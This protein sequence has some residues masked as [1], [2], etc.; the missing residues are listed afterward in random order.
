[1][2]VGSNPIPKYQVRLTETL[3]TTILANIKEWCSLLV[4]QWFLLLVEH[5]ELL[6]AHI[7][8]DLPLTFSPL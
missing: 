4:I 2:I 5:Y 6:H 7:D 8:S 3:P 1:M